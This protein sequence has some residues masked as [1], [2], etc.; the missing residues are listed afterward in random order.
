MK[1]IVS[2]K[3]R[4][5]KIPPA[6]CQ[7]IKFDL[8][9]VNPKYLDNERMNRWQGNTEK[10]LFHYKEFKTIPLL[11]TPRGYLNELLRLTDE[12]GISVSIKNIT[13]TKTPV[14]FEFN[15]ELKDFQIPANTAM[16]K[17]DIGVL[18]APTGSGKTVM[19]L[20]LIYERQQ[21]AI[22]VV[23]TKELLQ[24]WIERINTFLKI[25]RS[26]IGIISGDE[27][28]L[29]TKITVAMAQTLF[30][31]TAKFSD[32][33]GHL[34][35]DECHRCPSRTFLEIVGSFPCKYLLGLSATPYRRDKLTKLIY[36]YLGNK[37]YSIS[38]TALT[39]KGHILP[40]EIQWVLTEF[41]T[42][43]DCTHEYSK[44]MSELSKNE[45]RNNLVCQKINE[46]NN[47]KDGITLI[48]TDR[49]N[50]CDILARILK[51]EYKLS[52]VI[53]TGAITSKK[54]RERIVQNLIAGKTKILI[55]TGQLIGE[56]F[57]LPKLENIFLTMPVKFK[58]RLIQ[59]IGRCARPSKNQNT[60]NVID[61][62]DLKIK[63]L[64]NSAKH[65]FGIYQSLN[66]KIN[67]LPIYQN[68]EIVSNSKIK[69]K[70]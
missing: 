15:G 51:D 59:L 39:K 61:F 70:K 25:P 62:V 21:P 48:I 33:I 41:Q 66:A 4:I 42:Q 7:A 40:F 38:Q 28:R 1:I 12:Y 2:N 10:Y 6:L 14:N 23:H 53:L 44:M 34:I 52:S 9:F 29:G 3:L 30:K 46:I 20:H 13:K 11:Q 58:G 55:A 68:K 24:Q 37:E 19:A 54:E 60:A 50:H 5:T 35:I 45:E 26:E 17:Q 63:T 49:Q 36:L 31:Y 16:L 43:Y 64:Y 47:S 32:K 65:R 27:K 8:T 22:I 57:D 18:Q 69:L 56:G 67:P